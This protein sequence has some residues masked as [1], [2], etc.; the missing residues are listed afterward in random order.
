[1]SPY[2][3]CAI[4]APFALVA[5]AVL[6]RGIASNSRAW[7][8][9]SEQLPVE[10]AGP[11]PFDTPEPKRA[12][13][14]ERTILRLNRWDMPPTPSIDPRAFMLP[15]HFLDGPTDSHAAMHIAATC[16][17]SAPDCSPSCDTGCCDTGCDSG[18]CDAGGCGGCD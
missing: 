12:P 3:V 9:G 13:P 4:V 18:G 1:M 2:I 15:S 11:N 17:D 7:E 14:P 6:F 16:A 5:L 10:G 8:D